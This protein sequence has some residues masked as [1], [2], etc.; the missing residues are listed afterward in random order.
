MSR[1]SAA[2]QRTT[3]QGNTLQHCNAQQRT[4]MQCDTIATRTHPYLKIYA[5]RQVSAA[6][7]HCNVLQH[8]ATLCNALQHTATHCKTLQH[9]ATHCNTPPYTTQNCNTIVTRTHPCLKIHAMRRISAAVMHCN[10][11]QHTATLY[12]ALQYTATHCNTLQHTAT[13]CN[14]L[15]HILQHNSN[16]HCNKIATH[17][18]PYLQTMPTTPLIEAR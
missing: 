5:V 12:N 3:R 17:I 18:H 16:T 7:M 8:T 2:L 9:T 1:V 13:H 6:V 14:T 15:Q 11:L 4:A 10:V